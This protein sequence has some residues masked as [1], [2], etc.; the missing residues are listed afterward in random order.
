MLD[1]NIIPLIFG[2]KFDESY[3]QPTYLHF[4]K[5][6]KELKKM[7]NEAKNVIY[8]LRNSF[9]SM[10]RVQIITHITHYSKNIPST[11]TPQQNNSLE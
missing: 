7:Q 2:Y 5:I 1:A 10:K 8:L 4:T 3:D 11:N 9:V 6:R